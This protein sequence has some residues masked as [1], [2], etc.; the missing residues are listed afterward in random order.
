ML[1]V[2]L[3]LDT[4]CIGPGASW[5]VK[6]KFSATCALPEATQHELQ[7]NLQMVATCSGL[8]CAWVWPSCELRLAV[9]SARSE[10]A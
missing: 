9:T 8:G 5:E 2:G 7:S 4:R 10:A 6:V 3:K 1:S